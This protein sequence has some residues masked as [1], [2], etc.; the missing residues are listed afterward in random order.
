MNL[1]CGFLEPFVTFSLFQGPNNHLSEGE[2]SVRGK[3]YL[4]KGLTGGKCE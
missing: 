3:K 2:A 1:F 4:P